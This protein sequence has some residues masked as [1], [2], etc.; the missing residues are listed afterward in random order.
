[1]TSTCVGT[2][3]PL[4]S[5]VSVVECQRQP[6]SLAVGLNLFLPCTP[7]LTIHSSP[8]LSYDSIS[9]FRPHNMQGLHSSLQNFL[10]KGTMQF[11]SYHQ[12][13][14]VPLSIPP[15][16]GVSITP[17]CCRQQTTF[18][19]IYS[20]WSNSQF[21][22]VI[23]IFFFFTAAFISLHIYF[24]WFIVSHPAVVV[25][26]NPSCYLHIVNRLAVSM[27]FHSI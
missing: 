11:Q 2:D 5:Y 9:H 7:A 20:C 10:Q 1:M 14:I 19:G 6:F 24:L 27:W 4:P 26:F 15:A 18:H 22:A 12:P 23:H 25:Q 17:C 8:L 13:C 3:F 16:M 21:T